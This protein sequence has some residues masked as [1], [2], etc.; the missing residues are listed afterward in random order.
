M[1]LCGLG[2]ATLKVREWTAK[3][4]WDV[5]NNESTLKPNNIIHHSNVFNFYK[6][7]YKNN[8]MFVLKFDKTLTFRYCCCCCVCVFFFSFLRNVFLVV[9]GGD[10][11]EG[12]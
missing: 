10:I 9:R 3:Q 6:N 4:E 2:G 1:C 12:T 8:I 11:E 5:V 7:S